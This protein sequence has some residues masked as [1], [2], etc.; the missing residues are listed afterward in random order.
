MHVF[1]CQGII[2]IFRT[3]YNFKY[4]PLPKNLKF[5]PGTKLQNLFYAYH[6]QIKCA[7][8]RKQH[9]TAF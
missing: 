2:I 6:L 9:P 3:N 8:G 7:S 1:L 5:W 4:T